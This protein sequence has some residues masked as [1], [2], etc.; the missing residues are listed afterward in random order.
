MAGAGEDAPYFKNK[1]IYKMYPSSIL[2]AK[3]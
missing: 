2:P 3:S 1:Y